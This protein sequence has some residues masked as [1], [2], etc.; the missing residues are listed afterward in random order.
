MKAVHATSHKESP[1]KT[2]CVAQGDAINW[3]RQARKK[4]RGTSLT[5]NTKRSSTLWHTHIST[6]LQSALPKAVGGN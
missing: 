4:R 3:P 1:H 5:G 2:K 6:T